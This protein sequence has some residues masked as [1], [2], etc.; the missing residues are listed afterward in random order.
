MSSQ[1]A[2]YGASVLFT[3]RTKLGQCYPSISCVLDGKS[4]TDFVAGSGLRTL[5][6]IADDYKFPYQ[7]TASGGI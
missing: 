5:S 4:V 6:L 3:D 1:Q 2:N 7:R